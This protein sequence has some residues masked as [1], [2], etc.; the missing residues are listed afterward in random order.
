MLD[1][2]IATPGADAHSEIVACDSRAPNSDRCAL[3]QSVRVKAAE[4]RELLQN[5]E[6]H[7]DEQHQH[8]KATADVDDMQ[9]LQDADPYR[10]LADAKHSL[11]SGVMFAER[12]I[13]Q[14]TAF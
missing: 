3:I 7:I 5:I 6:L 1:T 9:R 2:Q 12:A 11:Q 10:W 4:L 13:T 14:P 8:A